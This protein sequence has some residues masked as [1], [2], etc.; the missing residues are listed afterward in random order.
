[1]VSFLSTMASRPRLLVLLG[2]LET[3]CLSAYAFATPLAYPPSALA[4]SS[5][6]VNTTSG[7]ITGFL[8]STTTST[9]LLKY[10]G[11][12]YASS[13]SGSNRWAPPKPYFD[14][15]LFNATEFGPACMQGRADGGAGTS[16]QSEDCL[17]VNVIVPVLDGKGN[18]DGLLPVYVYA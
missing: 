12:R 5:L 10:Y 11:I 16:V 8:D 9:H 17:R 15:D 2:I 7:P 18:E 14:P 4:F 13:T 6:T 1:M 3:F